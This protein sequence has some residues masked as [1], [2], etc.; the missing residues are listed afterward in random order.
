MKAMEALGW[1]MA[2]DEGETDMATTVCFEMVVLV[3]EDLC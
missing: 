1:V 3:D 2:V